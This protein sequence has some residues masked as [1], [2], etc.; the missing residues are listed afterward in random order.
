MI[1]F[2]EGKVSAKSE[3]YF[4]IQTAGVGFKIVSHEQV[5][6]KIPE[7]GESVKV[8]TYLYLHE[9]ARRFVVELYGF[10]DVEELEFFESLISISGIGPRSA[11]GVLSR[12]PVRTLKQAIVSED[13]TFFTKVSGIGKKTAQKLIFELKTRLS[14]EIKA[15][16]GSNSEVLSQALEALTSLGYKER[17]ARE[18]LQKLPKEMGTVEEKVKAALKYLGKK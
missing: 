5:I 4:I 10:L 2:L 3:K 6:S 8:W 16:P 13:E 1:N 15:I 17:D 18:I 7:T 14:K 11:L 12:A 9:D